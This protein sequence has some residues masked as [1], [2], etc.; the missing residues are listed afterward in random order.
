GNANCDALVDGTDLAIL[1]T[2][3]GFIA[4]PGGAVPEPVTIGLLS[5]GGL[6]LLRRRRR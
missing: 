5:L 1:K 2:N 4:P 3:F 6:T